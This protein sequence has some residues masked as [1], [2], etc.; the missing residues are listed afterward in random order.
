MGQAWGAW[1]RGAGPHPSQIPTRGHPPN[2][3][4]ASSLCVQV[5]PSQPS[6]QMQE[7]ESPLPTQVPPFM[8]GL[9]RQLLF[10]AV[11]GRRK[12]ICSSGGLHTVAPTQPEAERAQGRGRQA[13]CVCGGGART[14]CTPHSPK[15]SHRCC[16]RCPSS[17]GGRHSG[18]C[19]RCHSTCRH[20]CKCRRHTGTRL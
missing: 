11:R 3:P 17:P 6:R 14:C 15:L 5:R 8:Q 18:R 7:K 9:G 20:C 2:T 16:K 1:W 12:R 19:H 10:L 13:W 4:T